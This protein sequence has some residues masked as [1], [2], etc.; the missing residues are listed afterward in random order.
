MKKILLA[1]ALIAATA[2]PA[3]A[4]NFTNEYCQTCQ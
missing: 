1:L 3:M 4:Q 2:A